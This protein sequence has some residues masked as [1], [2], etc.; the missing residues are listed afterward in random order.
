MRLDTKFVCFS[1]LLEVFDSCFWVLPLGMA[2][3][4]GAGAELVIVYSV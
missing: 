1:S 3:G 2:E 4:C